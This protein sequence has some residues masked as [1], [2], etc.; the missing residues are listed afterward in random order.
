MMALLW[1]TAWSKDQLGT[2]G[3]WILS[4]IDNEPD[5]VGGLQSLDVLG[6]A[7]LLALFTNGKLPDSMVGMYGF[8]KDDQFEW[9]G[10]TFDI[11]PDEAPLGSLLWT[12]RRMPLTDETAKMAVHFA[13]EA[14]QVLVKNKW[15]GSFAITYEIDKLAGRLSL[16]IATDT[17]RGRTYIADLFALQ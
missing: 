7:I 8:N 3:D 4:Q 16:A 12:I 13:A 14:L 10:N 17:P 2:V 11:Q 6:T 15:V 9:H 5:N 1:D